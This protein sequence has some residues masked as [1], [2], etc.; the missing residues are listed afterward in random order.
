MS[1][2][3][4]IAL[5]F[6]YTNALSAPFGLNEGM[7]L[8]EINKMGKFSADQSSPYIYISKELKNGNSDFEKYTVIVTP[9][10]GLCKVIATGKTIESSI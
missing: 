8:N 3:L 5:T 6:I 2:F 7:S 4:L 1:K 10:Q 9:Q